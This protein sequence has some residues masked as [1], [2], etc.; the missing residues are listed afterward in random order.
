M[1]ETMASEMN[2]YSNLLKESIKSILYS[3]I[4]VSSYCASVYSGVNRVVVF[5]L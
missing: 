4:T 1:T 2:V 5:D 3:L